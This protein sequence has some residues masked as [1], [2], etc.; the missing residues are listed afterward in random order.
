MSLNYHLNRV[1]GD[2]EPAAKAPATR[3]TVLEGWEFMLAGGGLY[4]HL[5]Y[6]FA[7]GHEDGWFVNP[8]TQQAAEAPPCGRN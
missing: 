4:N 2:N 3:T 1:I 5:D 6:S 7:V 8:P